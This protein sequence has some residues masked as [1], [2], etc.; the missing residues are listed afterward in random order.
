MLPVAQA[1]KAA[2]AAASIFSR[3]DSVIVMLFA[4]AIDSAYTRETMP[5]Q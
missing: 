4:L 5:L 2:V 1:G 3:S